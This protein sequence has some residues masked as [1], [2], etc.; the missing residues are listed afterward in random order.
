M[1]PFFAIFI[2]LLPFL[3]SAGLLQAQSWTLSGFVEDG[4][5]GERL[6]AAKVTALGQQAGAVTN[7][8]GYYS[9]T[10]PQDSVTLAVTYPGYPPL[11][12]RMLLQ[13]DTTLNLVLI[14]SQQ[15]VVEITDENRLSDAS[16]S[17]T[18]SI[19]MEQAKMIP[20]LLGEVDLLKVFQLLP[21]TQTA[22]EGSAGFYVRG[23][24]AD[25]NLILLDEAPVYNASHL[26]GFFSVFNPDAVSR[27]ELIYSGFPAKYG[28]RVSSVLEVKL[29]E[30]NNKELKG[31]GGIGIISSRF[32]LEGPLAKGKSS[33]MVSGRRTYLDLLTNPINRMNRDR[34][35]WNNI[36]AYWFYDLNAKVNYR[37]SDKDRLYLSGYFGRD[38]FSFEQYRYNYDF[39]WGNA[40]ATARWNHVFGKRTFMNVTGIFS[41]YGYKMRNYNDLWDMQLSSGI[42]NFSVKADFEFYP[43][44]RHT[45]RYGAV[46]IRHVFS[47]ASVAGGSV[48]SV[49]QVNTERRYTGLESAVYLSD[50]IHLGS[51]WDMHLGMRFSSFIDSSKLYLGP[52][53][54]FSLVYKPSDK[55]GLRI[56]Y[57]H[58]Y[59]YMHLVSGTNVT[60]PADMWF[61]S[62]DIIPPQIADQLSAGA[63]WLPGSKGQW[64]FMTDVYYKWMRNQIE[65]E[66]GSNF[67]LSPDI[68]KNFVFGKGWSYG[69]EWL[70]RKEKGKVKGWISYTLSWTNR[71]FDSLN[72]GRPYPVKYDRRHDLAVVLAWDVSKR[73]SLNA[74]WQFATGS[75]MT[76]PVGRYVIF[77]FD[78]PGYFDVL[79]YYAD[80]NSFRMPP[81]HKM[82]MS[83]NWKMPNRH[84]W[85][86]EIVFSIYNVY[87]RRNPYFIYFDSV[88]NEQHQVLRYEARQISLFPIIPSVS[89]NFKF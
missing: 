76:L 66:E 86:S 81:F 15:E 28:G 53:P 31:E 89:Y 55:W 61:P 21:Q 64:T 88:K 17:G 1:R 78:T 85:Q 39:D 41:D 14:G 2:W 84:K 73:V 77:G 35:N 4:E 6:A 48:D 52:E 29:K 12:V 30:G 22:N 79:P 25:Q 74:S 11:L 59:Q 60:V 36:P 9:L 47:P 16:T 75:A 34:P 58:L 51:R 63:T 49:F 68:E 32:T 70:L 71:Q 10:L 82:D 20:A 65:L 43:S 44:Q 62:S 8:Y 45:I 24:S 33:F 69:S 80:R 57:T 38:Y 67:F 87:S 83:L 5:T 42:R 40:T 13:S 7:N 26:F 18:I 27:M 56:N 54:R 72:L 3:L 19:P 50:D 46:A 37:L 23:G